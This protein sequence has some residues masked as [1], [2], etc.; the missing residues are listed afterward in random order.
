MRSFLCACRDPGP[1]RALRWVTWAPPLT[2]LSSPS[3]ARP[4]ATCLLGWD[5]LGPA[6][7]QRDDVSL[8]VLEPRGPL[9]LHLRDPARCLEPGKVVVLENDSLLAQTRNGRFYVV[10]VESELRVIA[11]RLPM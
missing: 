1:S 5:A 8:R 4:G 10:D 3:D 6:L 7:A 9:F 2:P 11:G